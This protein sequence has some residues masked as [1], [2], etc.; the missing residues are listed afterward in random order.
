MKHGRKPTLKQKNRIKAHGLNPDNWLI[1]KDTT[2]LFELVHRES[3]NIRRFEKE[4]S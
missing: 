1:V 2:E 3:G 4:L